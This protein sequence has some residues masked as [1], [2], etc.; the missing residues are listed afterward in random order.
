MISS[1]IRSLRRS[2]RLTCKL[3]PLKGRKKHP[4]H[5]QNEVSLT[6]FC[7]WSGCSF[8]DET[9]KNNF[10]FFKV[11]MTRI[12]FG[13][14]E[15]Y[16]VWNTRFRSLRCLGRC[17]ERLKLGHFDVTNGQGTGP[18]SLWM[19]RHV[20]AKHEIV[21]DIEGFQMRREMSSD[22]EDSYISELSDF[23]H[24]ETSQTS[25]SCISNNIL[26]NRTEKNFVSYA[27]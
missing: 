6:S 23:D 1:E 15:K 4:E 26:F 12:C 10:D 17:Y 19:W 27:L 24:E 3:K 22:S 25:K 5:A 9:E 21:V 2:S 7:A 16:V 14:V 20:G 18:S 8:H 13:T 11:H